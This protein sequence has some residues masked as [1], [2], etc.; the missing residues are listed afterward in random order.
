MHTDTLTRTHAHGPCVYAT[1]GCSSPAAGR[2]LENWCLVCDRSHERTRPTRHRDR[3]RLLYTR[4]NY[5]RPCRQNRVADNSPPR[6]TRKCE[7]HTHA[8]PT[9]TIHY[10]MVRV[11]GRTTAAA[12]ASGNRVRAV[13]GRCGLQAGTSV[14][15]NGLTDSRTHARQYVSRSAVTEQRGRGGKGSRRVETEKLRRKCSRREV[16]RPVPIEAMVR[17]SR[18]TVRVSFPKHFTTQIIATLCRHLLLL[19]GA[20]VTITMITHVH[21][22]RYDRPNTICVCSTIHVDT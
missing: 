15:H 14:R 10:C 3:F 16:A 19:K 20:S 2:T 6:Q 5:F 17:M 9:Q 18:N 13:Q 7:T 12:A 21:C 1:M 11:Y 22:T 8:R 4:G